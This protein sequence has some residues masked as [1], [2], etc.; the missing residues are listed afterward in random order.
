M[1]TQ[2]ALTWSVTS[3]GGTI[4]ATSGLYT[5]PATAGTAT[6]QAASGGIAG[7][8]SVTV[9]PPASVSAT[10]TFSLVLGPGTPGSRPASPSPIRARTPITN[11]VLQFNFAATITSIWNATIASQTG[12]QYVID[13]AGYNSTIA[14]GQ[15]VTFGF[16]GSPGACPAAPTNYVLNGTPIAG[17]RTSARPRRGHG[18]V[19]RR[20]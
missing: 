2:P 6:V 16:L 20:R 10:A 19:R 7:T 3:G 15:S 11:W 8:A 17:Y 13:N 14:A 1:A 9:S 4:G 5:A 12:T 18:D